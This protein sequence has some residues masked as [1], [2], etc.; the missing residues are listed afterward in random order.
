M[1]PV[2][3]LNE[4]KMDFA[5]RLLIGLNTL[6]INGKVTQLKAECDNRLSKKSDVGI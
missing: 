2:S 1:I 3:Q 4:E 5:D 6:D